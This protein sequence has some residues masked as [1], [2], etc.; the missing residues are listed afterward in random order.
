MNHVPSKAGHRPDAGSEHPIAVAAERT[1]LTQDVLRVWERRY[2]AVKPA[3]SASGQ[4]VYSDLDIE[5]LRLLHAATRAGRSISQIARLNTKALM[6][7]VGEDSAARAERAGVA[8]GS[9]DYT[10]IIDAALSL[11]ESLQGNEL[12]HQLR[13]AAATLGVPEFLSHVAVPLLRRVGDEWHA[14]RFT[15]A[16]E[17]L[18]SS[19]LHDIFVDRMRAFS[20]SA[21]APK[22]LIATPAGERHA[23]G[24]ALVGAAAAVEGWSVIYLGADLPASEIA[25]AAIAGGVIA[26]ALSVLYVDDRDR[27][28]GELRDLRARLPPGIALFVGGSGAV[29]LSREL[30]GPGV[31]VTGNVADLY[32]ELRRARA[33]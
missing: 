2:G 15:P 27:L 10:A 26:V 29:A 23:I 6:N 22:V 24:A 28:I 17:H 14:G 7:M 19:V 9:A 12:D 13:R 30:S 25:A 18:A 20:R 31:R 33:R 32:D 11:A 16:Q 5:R 1:G 8:P 4:R 3:R 21:D